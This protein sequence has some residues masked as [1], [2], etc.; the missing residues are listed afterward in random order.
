M[1]PPAPVDRATLVEDDVVTGTSVLSSDEELE[2][3]DEEGVIMTLVLEGS[4]EVEAGAVTILVDE[5]D[6]LVDVADVWLVTTDDELAEL[7]DDAVVEELVAEL[8]EAEEVT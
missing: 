4:V 8:D 3:E 7:V 1:V 2:V 6:W 5:N